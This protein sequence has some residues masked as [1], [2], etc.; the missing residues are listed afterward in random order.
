LTQ[1]AISRR[2]F[3]LVAGTAGVGLATGGSAAAAAEGSGKG[4]GMIYSEGLIES[5][6]T[7]FDVLEPAGGSSKPPMVLISGGAHTGSCYLATADGRPGWAQAFARAGHTVVVP[8]WP[9]VGRSGFIPPDEITGETIV[10]GLGQVIASLGRPAIV[11]THSMSGAYGWKLVEKFGQHIDKLV[12]IAPGSPGNIQAVSDIISETA[13][14]VVVKS[15]V[16]LTINLKKPV[17][18]DRNFVDVKLVGN[19]TQFPR[20]VIARYAS[21]LVPIPP[22]L[23]YERRNILGSQLKV[24]DFANYRGRR[25]LVV[26][27]TEDADHPRKLDE[28]IVTFFNQNGAKAD[29]IYLGDRGISGNGHMMMLEKNSDSIAALVL[30]WIEQG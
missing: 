13:D 17:V 5:P 27:G 22:R 7:Y 23:L 2:E 19:S 14:T 8:D 21:S 18:S 28:G 15:S 9:G 26:T 4:S 29:Y 6:P 12:A 16:T 30:S 24:A 10:A 20:E 3:G 25:I 1:D 11:M